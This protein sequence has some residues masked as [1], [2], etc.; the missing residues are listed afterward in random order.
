MIEVQRGHFVLQNLFGR[1]VKVLFHHRIWAEKNATKRRRWIQL[2]RK[3]NTVRGM[4]SHF[5]ALIFIVRST[6]ATLHSLI[7]FIL[8]LHLCVITAN[9]QTPCKWCRYEQTRYENH[10][11]DTVERLLQYCKRPILCLASSKIFHP[12]PP[13]P[14]RV[15]TP[16]P[17]LCCGGRTHSLGGEGGGK[18]IFWKTQ[19]TALYSTYIESSLIDTLK[20][21]KNAHKI[22]DIWRMS[23]NLLDVF[24]V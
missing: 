3:E 18:S 13:S 15:C 21:K 14:R 1:W 2:A 20:N 24:P 7:F 11:I 8:I 12:L 5:E 19:D 16:P 23:M 22:R 6:E 4:W 17:R 10:I 9:L